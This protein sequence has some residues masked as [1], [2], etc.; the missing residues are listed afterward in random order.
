MV[1]LM[2][3]TKVPVEA[4]GQVLA[5]V[6]QV[7]SNNGADSRSMPDEYVAIAHFLCY[8]EEYTLEGVTK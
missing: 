7:A 2:I 5:E 1:G 4:I 8:P 6:M 3:K